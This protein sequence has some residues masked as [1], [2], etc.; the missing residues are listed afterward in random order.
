[1]VAH[2]ALEAL[3]LFS[4]FMSV[5]TLSLHV[6]RRAAGGAPELVTQVSET[7]VYSGSMGGA[8]AKGNNGRVERLK[9]CYYPHHLSQQVP[10]YSCVAR[11]RLHLPHWHPFVPTPP[12]TSLGGERVGR[13][14]TRTEGRHFS[15]SFL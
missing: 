2:K 3:S 14:G 8:A 6:L 11:S 5:L 1:M 7:R 12:G 15:S 10:P 9:N 4:L 13:V